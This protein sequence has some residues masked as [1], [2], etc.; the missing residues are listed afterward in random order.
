MAVEYKDYYK[1]LEVDRKATKD[2]IAKSFKRLAR[3]LHPDFNPG[4]AAA[5]RKFKDITEA[6]EVLKDDEKRRLYD[7]LGADWQHGQQF[8]HQGFG[9]SPYGGGSPFGGGGGQNFSG[10]SFSDFFETLFGG[11]SM[12]GGKGASFGPDPFASF[13]QRGNHKG[14]DVEATLQLTLEEAFRGGSKTVSVPTATGMSR[15]LEV[16]IPAGVRN[17]AR[18]R[19]SGQGEVGFGTQSQSGDLYLKVSLIPHPLFTLDENDIIY[20]LAITPWEAV[21]GAKIRVPTLEGDVELAVPPGSGSNKKF[22]LR[23]KGLGTGANKGD[24]FVR[25]AVSV[26][27]ASSLSAEEKELWNKLH[28]ISTFTAR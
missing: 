6:Y 3:K 10:S 12:R 25:I 24:Q 27:E 9:G 4:D 1:L 7:Q 20:E 2:Q 26:P 23:G 16:K 5:E 28:D 13:S 17:G 19:L 11:A 14:Q 22:R 8:Q 15:N 18:I 21:L